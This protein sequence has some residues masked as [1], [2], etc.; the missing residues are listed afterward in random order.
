M[1]AAPS[2]LVNHG[3]TIKLPY[4]LS[5]DKEPRIMRIPT[6]MLRTASIATPAG[7]FANLIHL[8]RV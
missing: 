4:P 7:T 2:I 6:N 1:I 8:S 5:N 3:P